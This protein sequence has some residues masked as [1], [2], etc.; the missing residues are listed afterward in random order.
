MRNRSP[1][2]FRLLCAAFLLLIT[3]GSWPALAQGPTG[4]IEGVVRD[5]QGGVLP[6]VAMTLR[7]KE[8]GVTRTPDPPQSAR[9][10]TTRCSISRCETMESAGPIRTATVSSV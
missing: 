6:G 5:E 9:E 7:N 3:A 4:V 8:T 2:A 1:R 10:S